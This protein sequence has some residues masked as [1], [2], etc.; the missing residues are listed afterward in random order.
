MRPLLGVLLWPGRPAFVA[1]SSA[2]EDTVSS[3]EG[4]ADRD[5]GRT[6]DP[7][8]EWCGLCACD[9]CGEA[10]VDAPREPSTAVRSG[11]EDAFEETEGEEETAE[12]GEAV[13]EAATVAAAVALAFDFSSGGASVS[14]RRMALRLWSF[15]PGGAAGSL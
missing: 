12:A 11:M 15:R 10:C 7:W 3:G 13:T 6:A 5:S 2:G 14:V 9:T 8:R 1:A 4:A